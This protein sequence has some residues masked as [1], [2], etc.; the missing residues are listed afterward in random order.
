MATWHKAFY[1]WYAFAHGKRLSVR[2]YRRGDGGGF[3]YVARVNESAKHSPARPHATA[4]AAK[5][6]AESFAQPK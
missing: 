3:V 1:G 6:E 2:R 5:A 4:S